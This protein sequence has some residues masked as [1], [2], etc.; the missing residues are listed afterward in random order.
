[1][2]AKPL[3]SC[4]GFI[5]GIVP[6]ARVARAVS[7]R[8]Y[9]RRVNRKICIFARCLRAPRE[10]R[11]ARHGE[12][13]P[14]G[15]EGGQERRVLHA[16]PRHRGGDERLPRL[17]RG[18][19]PREDGAAAVRRPGVE[20]LHALLRGAVPGPRGQ[21]AHQHELRAGEQAV[22]GAM[23]TDHLRDAQPALPPGTVAAT[24]EDLHPRPRRQWGRAGRHRRHAVGLPRG[25]RRLPR[26][27]GDGPARRRGHHRHQPPLLPL[28][29]VPGV[30]RGR[31][32]AVRHHREHQRDHLP[33]GVPADPGQ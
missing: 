5:A 14:G 24:G 29:G 11:R 20:Q 15:R 25:R 4:V 8:R 33:G 1:M 19:V 10:E 17:R 16:A 21:A 26:R 12:Y 22:R 9:P 23:A 31:G 2:Y 7:S 30:G 6:A 32:A 18:C 3:G 27:G 13:E 28:P